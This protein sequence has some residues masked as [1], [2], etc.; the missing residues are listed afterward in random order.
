M[1]MFSIIPILLSFGIPVLHCFVSQLPSLSYYL[2]EC[3][4]H[5]YFATSTLWGDPNGVF[6]NQ[7]TENIIE[8][9]ILR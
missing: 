2:T 6:S 4:Q 9:D 1:H 3:F 5:I 8:L 7:M